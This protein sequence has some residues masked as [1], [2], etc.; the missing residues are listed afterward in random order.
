MCGA[1]KFQDG[2]GERVNKVNKV[3]IQD[4]LGGLVTICSIVV[5]RFHEFSRQPSLLISIIS[6]ESYVLSQDV[7]LYESRCVSS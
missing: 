6:Y 1:S 4:H 3:N 5:Y 2:K 7:V